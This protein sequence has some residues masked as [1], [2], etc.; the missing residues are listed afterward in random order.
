MNTRQQDILLLTE[1]YGEITI[2]A[3]AER[4]GVSEMTIHRDLDYLQAEKRIRKKRGAAVFVESAHR[5]DLILYA[6][7]KRAIGRMA[8]SFLQTGQSVIFDNSTTALECARFLEDTLHLTCYTT[9]LEIAQLLAQNGKHILYC[10]GGYYFPDSRGFLGSH[11]EA[12]VASVHADIAIIGASGISVEKGITNPYPMHTSLQQ[13]ILRSAD[14]CILLADHSKF[15][16]VAM[17]KT[18]ELS[19]IDTVVTDWGLTESQREI[20]GKKTNLIIAQKE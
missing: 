4:L 3:L 10:S 1:Q 12:F 16:R 5:N 6:E 2:K 8:A 11:A 17:E 14:R 7:E 15:D 18:S 9:N 19:E 20:Y 13:Q